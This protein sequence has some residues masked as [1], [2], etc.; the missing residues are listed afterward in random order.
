MRAALV[1][2]LLPCAV[3]AQ[4]AG[5]VVNVSKSKMDERETFTA[6]LRAT[7]PLSNRFGTPAL[8]TLGIRCANGS[9]DLI[10]RPDMVLD[11]Y[12]R[13]GSASVRMRYDAEPASSVAAGISTDHRA[14]FIRGAASAIERMATSQ[15]VLIEFS[16]FRSGPKVA[17]FAIASLAEHAPLIAEHCGVAIK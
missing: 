15:R 3:A 2:L 17:E 12:G 5:W 14:L 8:P 11:S 1:A 7:E 13:Y 4:D 6:I 10:F 16:P 9:A